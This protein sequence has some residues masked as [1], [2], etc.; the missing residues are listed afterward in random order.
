[1]SP[2]N[3]QLN[4]HSVL[5]QNNLGIQDFVWSVEEWSNVNHDDF[6][7]GEELP[8][9][10]LTDGEN[11]EGPETEIL[12]KKLTEASEKWGF[13]ILVNHGVSREVIERFQEQCNGLFDLPMLQ[14]MKGARSETLPLGYSASNPDYAKN[15]PWAEIFQ[16]LQSPKQILEF[17]MKVWGEESQSHK[18]FR[19]IQDSF[20]I[21]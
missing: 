19:Y 3:E 9:I 16:I 18:S 4:G 8:I 15:L 7:G 14:K 13:F 21:D 6:S 11:N 12:C 10:S 20:L 5:L 2:Q 1:M 17:S